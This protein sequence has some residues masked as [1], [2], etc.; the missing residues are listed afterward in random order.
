[1]SD[2]LNNNASNSAADIWSDGGGGGQQY[3][4]GQGQQT[5]DGQQQQTDDGQQQ[6]QDGQQQQLAQQAAQQGITPDQLKQILSQFAPQQQPQ[7][8]PQRQF[9]QEDFNRA[10]NVVQITP[11][12]LAQFGLPSTPEAAQAFQSLVG[13]IV[14][15]AVTMNAY[16][17]EN[18]M[19]QVHQQLTPVQQM[20]REQKEQQLKGE[21]LQKYPDMKGYE[22]LLETVQTQLQ[23]E[24]YKP[25]ATNP[26]EA[27]KEVFDAVYGRAKQLLQQLPGLQQQQ[28]QQQQQQGGQQPPQQQQQRQAANKMSTVSAGGQ[29]GSGGQGG[30]K[31]TTAQQIFG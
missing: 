20:V 16:Q 5:D 28:G 3:D 18:R 22:P 14:K 13:D 11:D 30:G 1:M 27:K 23:N 21:F 25:T 15:Q 4:F 29:G 31:K 17:L 9:T 26:N 7:Q 10:M 8:A 2:D 6:Q 19:Q 12:R 24:G